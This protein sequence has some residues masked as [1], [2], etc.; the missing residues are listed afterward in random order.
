MADKRSSLGKGPDA[1]LKNL[2][3]KTPSLKRSSSM[4]AWLYRGSETSVQDGKRIGGQ[5]YTNEASGLGDEKNMT[6]KD[7]IMHP[8]EVSMRLNENKLKIQEQHQHIQEL[9][10]QLSRAKEVI[11]EK[12]KTIQEKDKILEDQKKSLKE[13]DNYIQEWSKLALNLIKKMESASNKSSEVISDFRTESEKDKIL[14]QRFAEFE[15]DVQ[16]KLAEVFFNTIKDNRAQI[17]SRRSA[18]EG[19]HALGFAPKFIEMLDKQEVDNHELQLL[20]FEKIIKDV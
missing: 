14:R 17:G 8:N 16:E 19:L 12:D 2:D 9:D 3:Q 5:P 4:P 10:N 15:K 18:V 1:S 20:M 6:T 13:K 7:V 11:Q